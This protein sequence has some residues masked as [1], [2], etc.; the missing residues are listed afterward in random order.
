MNPLRLSPIFLFAFLAL[1]PSLGGCGDSGGPD[2]KAQEARVATAMEMRK[3]FDAV[4]GD[5]TKVSA[6]DKAAFEK[7]A[8]GGAAAEKLWA[9]MKNGPGG[10]SSGPSR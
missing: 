8:G 4:G 5:Y 10:A 3:V 7:F 6:A 9:E 1:V 2:P